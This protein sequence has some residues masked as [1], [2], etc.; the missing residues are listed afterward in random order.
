MYHIRHFV[1]RHIYEDTCS[2]ND[3][4][5]FFIYFIIVIRYTQTHGETRSN[6]GHCFR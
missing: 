6:V 3:E 5:F 4:L 2:K 1:Y